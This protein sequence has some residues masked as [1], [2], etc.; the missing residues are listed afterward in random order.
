M[1]ITGEGRIDSQSIHGKTPVGVARAAKK[2]DIPVIAIAG[3]VS[4]DV[5]VVYDHGIDAVFSVVTGAMSLEEALKNAKF[6]LEQTSANVA[7]AM[8]ISAR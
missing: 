2:F 5:D 4:K 3:S 7:R 6:N 1:V 8:L